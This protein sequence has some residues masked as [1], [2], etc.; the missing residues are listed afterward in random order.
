VYRH[1]MTRRK[2]L[3][4]QPSIPQTSLTRDE[5]INLILA[6]IALEELGLS[7]I[8]NAEGEKIQYILGT[9][10]GL[11]GSATVSDV[12]ATDKSVRC[13]L[14]GVVQE[15]L[16]L[17]TKLDAALHATNLTGPTGP[18]GPTG[19]TGATGA[20]GATGETGATGATGETGATGATGETGATGA[21]GETGATG[22]TGE[23]GATGATGTSLVLGGLQLQLTGLPSGTIED[24]A[25]IPFDTL[26]NSQTP[27]I[28]YS[29]FGVFTIN[30]NGNYFVSW[31]VTT[32]GA[33]AITYVNF[34]LELNGSGVGQGSSPIVS[35]QLNGSSLVTVGTAPATLAL[36]NATG[37]TISYGNNPVQ[38]NIVIVELAP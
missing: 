8:L 5:A 20:T 13:V 10:P 22:A 27:D 29:G 21:T 2:T 4:S 7:H 1:I 35:G 33:E 32:D 25:P 24:G 37:T 3:M 38:A 26:I 18:T 31:W 28:I 15:Q 14:D 23:T 6:S 11:S 34:E 9:I 17:K 19:D 16:L 36:V 30:T 12:L